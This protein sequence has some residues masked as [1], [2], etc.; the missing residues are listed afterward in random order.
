MFDFKLT[1]DLQSMFIMKIPSF[2]AFL[3]P[4]GI[5]YQQYKVAYQLGSAGA[6]IYAAQ[7]ILSRRALMIGS[8]ALVGVVYYYGGHQLRS[9]L[10]DKI[11]KIVRNQALRFLF[12]QDSAFFKY[13]QQVET[14][15]QENQKTEKSLIDLQNMNQRLD[16]LKTKMAS[17]LNTA[18]QQIE[19]AKQKVAADHEK[20]LELQKLAN[21]A[22]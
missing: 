21:L 11:D 7:R 10:M 3:T 14:M 18:E 4:I 6:C 12:P 1:N 15:K 8:A 22:C 20:A 16:E 13:A 17:G 9:Y 19:K 5:H 2:D